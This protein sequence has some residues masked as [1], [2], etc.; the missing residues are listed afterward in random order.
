MK[1]EV[2]GVIF[3]LAGGC[4]GTVRFLRTVFVYELSGQFQLA[5]CGANA[6]GG[7]VA[8]VVRTTA[9]AG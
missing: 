8:C 3:T 9:A 7:R 6:G 2:R 4:L 1:K 5:D